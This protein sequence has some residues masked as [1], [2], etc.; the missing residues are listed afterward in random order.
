MK[1]LRTEGLSEFDVGDDL[2]LQSH[3]W[4]AGLIVQGACSDLPAGNIAGRCS[5]IRGVEIANQGYRLPV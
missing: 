3:T 2:N 4:K 5:E 1:P